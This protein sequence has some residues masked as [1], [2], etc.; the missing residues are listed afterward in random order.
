M[1]KAKALSALERMGRIVAAMKE[2]E[3][4]TVGKYQK[5]LRAAEVFYDKDGI[6]INQDDVDKAIE[7]A[8]TRVGDEFASL[9]TAPAYEGK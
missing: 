4:K 5:K 7:E 9:L 8:R 1:D 6:T 3:P 2:L